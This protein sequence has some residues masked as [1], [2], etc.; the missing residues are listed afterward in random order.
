MSC[1]LSGRFT[2]HHRDAIQRPSQAEFEEFVEIE[3]ELILFE[4]R[5]EERV[6]ATGRDGI[7]LWLISYHPLRGGRP[8]VLT[9]LCLHVA[10]HGKSL[11]VGEKGEQQF[12]FLSVDIGHSV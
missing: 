9:C 2:D 12:P 3:L 6:V 4:Q 7:E 11:D 5:V 8:G 1:S 10:G